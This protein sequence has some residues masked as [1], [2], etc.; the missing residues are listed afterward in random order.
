M[1]KLV[2]MLVLLQLFGFSCI[3]EPN[4]IIRGHQQVQSPQSKVHLALNLA[5]KVLVSFLGIW[6]IID[7]VSR[8]VSNKGT[9]TINLCFSYI[10]PKTVD[11]QSQPSVIKTQGRGILTE[12]LEKLHAKPPAQSSHPDLKD[13]SSVPPTKPPLSPK[14][15]RKSSDEKEEDKG[16]K[17]VVKKASKKIRGEKNEEEEEEEDKRE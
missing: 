1:K 17:K 2:V 5:T 16:E 7:L 6:V 3:R 8:N 13:E 4:I 14:K 10:S 11:V 12:D 15:D 9:D